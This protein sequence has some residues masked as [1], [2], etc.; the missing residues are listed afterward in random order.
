MTRR[1]F[2]LWGGLGLAAIGSYL[3][4]FIMARM[5]SVEEYGLLYSLIALTYLFSVPN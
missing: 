2:I 3:F 4:Y 5:L 1:A